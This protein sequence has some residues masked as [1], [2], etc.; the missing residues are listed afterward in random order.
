MC[1]SKDN[2]DGLV[3]DMGNIVLYYF[4]IPSA[5]MFQVAGGGGR[6]FFAHD[7]EALVDDR[8]FHWAQKLA[9]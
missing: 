1:D 2:A 4:L 3:A 7:L 5:V 8:F 9:H 6:S